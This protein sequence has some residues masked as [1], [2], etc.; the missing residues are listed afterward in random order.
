MYIPSIDLRDVSKRP[1]NN[2]S[3]RSVRTPKSGS[4]SARVAILPVIHGFEN[5]V[6]ADTVRET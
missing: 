1:L 3:T 4:Q 5:V 2:N 6:T